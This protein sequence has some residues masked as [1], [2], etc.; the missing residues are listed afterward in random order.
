MSTTEAPQRSSAP[1]SDIVVLDFGH[2]LAGPWAAMTLGDFGAKVIKVEKPG[3]GDTTRGTP[4]FFEGASSYFASANRN[5]LGVAID[6]KSEDGKRLLVELASKSD[7]LIHNFRPGVMERLGFGYEE[8]S[9]LNP[10][11]VY[12][13]ISGFG[14]ESALREKPAFD[15]VIQAM[16][17]LMAINGQP[18]AAP[19]RAGLPIADLAG[20][21]FAIIAILMALHRRARTG[22]GGFLDVSMFDALF[23]ML[24]DHVPYAHL[25]GKLPARSG[26]SHAQ[27]V[28]LGTFE[29]SDGHIVISAFT[30]GFWVNL[31]K[32][33]S[34]PEW[35][36][37]ERFA[38]ISKRQA[39]NALLTEEINKAMRQR[40]TA[41][42]VAEFD[43]LDV[44]HGPVLNLLEL[45]THPLVQ[46]RRLLEPL[47]GSGDSKVLGAVRPIKFSDYDA[48]V[49]MQ[50]PALGADTAEVLKSMLGLGDDEISRLRADGSIG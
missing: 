13:A 6:S 48:G 38:K 29:T 18:G 30:Q 23:N 47:L 49:R 2:V 44:P 33:L 3:R 24:V 1:L 7:V 9:K 10:R 45:L 15:P 21:V 27:A 26:A 14:H 28:P 31:C 34:R 40:T 16:S 37:D 46:E 11:L 39:N 32:A 5:K 22:S 8:L 17:G 41:E 50:A 4:P 20:G 42:W 43:R 25:T 19:L 36:E 35:I 12:C